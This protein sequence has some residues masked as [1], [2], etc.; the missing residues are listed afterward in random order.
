M[1]GWVVGRVFEGFMG[2]VVVGWVIGGFMGGLC[3]CVSGGGV[4][5]QRV[6]REGA[7][8]HPPMNSYNVKIFNFMN[9]YP[10][11]HQTYP[12]CYSVTIHILWRVHRVGE[13][14]VDEGF[15]GSVGG[16]VMG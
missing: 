3:G 13:G 12:K 7:Y 2:W 15:I 10:P 9:T 11:T 5:G 1:G 4:G 16:W 8:T 6:H 14:G